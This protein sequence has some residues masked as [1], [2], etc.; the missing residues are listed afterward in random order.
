VRLAAPSL[1]G[2]LVK[3]RRARPRYKPGE[4]VPGTGVY[5]IYHNAHRL[6]HEAALIENSLFPKCRKCKDAVRFVLA[7][8]TRGKSVLPFRSTEL[9][10]E[11]EDGEGKSVKAG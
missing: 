5:K 4:I 8:P 9:L 7:R 10:E 2:L 1:G 6:M 11:Y 3:E